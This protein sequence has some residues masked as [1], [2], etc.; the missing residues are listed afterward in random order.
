MQIKI[1]FTLMMEQ[2]S[3]PGYLVIADMDGQTFGH[4]RSISL[5]TSGKMLLFLQVFVVP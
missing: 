4:L 3:C 2:G 5:S 1:I